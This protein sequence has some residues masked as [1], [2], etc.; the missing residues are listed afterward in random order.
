[1]ARVLVVEDD[2]TVA[3]VLEVALGREGYL[4]FLVR[5][6]PSAK[7]A[8]QEDWDAIILD[9]NLPGGSGLD[10]LRY[11]RKELRKSTPVLILS[12]LKQERSLAEA[13]ALGAQEYFTKPFSPGD[14]I[15]RLKGYVAAR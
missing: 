4:S 5:D 10:L 1:M 6:Y 9:I 13:Q 11:L 12:G 14:L 3:K 7:V 8:L 15:K 2:P